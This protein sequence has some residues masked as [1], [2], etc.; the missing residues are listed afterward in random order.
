MRGHR[1]VDPDVSLL[2]QIVRQRIDAGELPRTPGPDR[3]WA[4]KGGGGLC[5]ACDQPLKP[6]DNEYE[7]VMDEE[8]PTACSLVF[9]RRC[10]DIWIAEC[11]E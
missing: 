10:L 6:C 3:L 2:R 7:V 8:L 9:H 1:Y 4:G 11:R 5:S